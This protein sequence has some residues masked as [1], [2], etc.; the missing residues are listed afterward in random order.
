[1]RRMFSCICCACFISWPMLPFM[2]GS[3]SI[4]PDSGV[5][6]LAVEHVDQVLHEAVALH[7]L[8][9]FGAA[10]LALAPASSAAA[11]APATS[12]TATLT[13]HGRPRCCSSAAFSL[14][15]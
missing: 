7:R 3:L 12:P 5:D 13:H 6:D 11:L 2:S 4:F 10:R 8:R 15:T 9:R 1:M 14:S